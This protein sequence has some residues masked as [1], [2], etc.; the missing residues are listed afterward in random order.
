[1]DIVKK[2]LVSII[3][4]V[5]DIL[6]V[7]AVFVWPVP[8][9][10]T[11]LSAQLDKSIALGNQIKSE[12]GMSRTLPNLD[13]DSNDPK[14]LDGFPTDETIKATQT[15]IDQFA[16]QA[17][18]MFDA[19]V[20]INTH[21]LLVPGELP[22]PDQDTAVKYQLAYATETDAYARWQRILNST[23]LPLPADVE[24]VRQRQHAAIEAKL[25]VTTNNQVTADS[26]AKA[27]AA[28]KESDEKVE[29]QIDMAKATDFSI[30]LLDKA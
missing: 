1:M 19:A 8:S 27:D 20:K 3:L 29:S 6:A 28:I 22:K 5:V 2:N 7:V 4:G 10:Y 26:R 14:P 21:Q 12:I 30:Y 13:P 17:A 15:A 23:G 9:K 24:A 11:A 25:L 18:S 16:K